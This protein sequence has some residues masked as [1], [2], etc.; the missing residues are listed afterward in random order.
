MA[1][2]RTLDDSPLSEFLTKMRDAHRRRVA[3]VDLA[4][5]R[6]IERE[7]TACMRQYLGRGAWE[8]AAAAEQEEAAQRAVPRVPRA[9]RR[10]ARPGVAPA[11]YR[12]GFDHKLAQ[13]GEP[14][15]D[16]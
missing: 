12:E 9:T 13:A 10:R 14:Q 5:K 15:G 16:E 6:A 2:P 4:D 3:A 11:K 1:K 8:A 7:M